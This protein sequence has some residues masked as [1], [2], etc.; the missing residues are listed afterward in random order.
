MQS[1]A[2]PLWRL[3]AQRAKALLQVPSCHHLAPGGSCQLKG[4]WLLSGFSFHLGLAPPGI[5]SS[6]WRDMAEVS[7][8]PGTP[9]KALAL[10]WMWGRTGHAGGGAGVLTSGVGRGGQTPWFTSP[11]GTQAPAQPPCEGGVLILAKEPRPFGDL[12]E[13]MGPTPPP[14]Q[15]LSHPELEGPRTDRQDWKAP[16]SSAP[17][18]CCRKGHG[19]RGA[20]RGFAEPRL[21]EIHSVFLHSPAQLP[22]Q[23]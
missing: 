12:P 13:H 6:Q 16:G 4:I 21:P 14:T 19:A 17:A 7:A 20:Q 8:R 18:C 9:G 2:Q 10:L 5:Q 3:G 11:F 15:P 23:S 1:L 22:G